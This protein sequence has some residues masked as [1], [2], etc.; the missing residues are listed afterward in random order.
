VRV[1]LNRGPRL[2]VLVGAPLWPV[3]GPVDV[4]GEL[5]VSD[6]GGGAVGGLMSVVESWTVVGY[7]VLVVAEVVVEWAVAAVVAGGGGA[8]G[9][10]GTLHWSDICTTVNTRVTSRISPTPPAANTA[11]GVRYQG[12]GSDAMGGDS[13]AGVGDRPPQLSWGTTS[14]ATSS[15]WA[16]SDISRSC[17]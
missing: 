5:D 6:P 12:S 10:A 15:R 8:T 2:E 1:S 11:L 3:D 7:V 4:A 14:V 17:R 16:R 9:D 13:N